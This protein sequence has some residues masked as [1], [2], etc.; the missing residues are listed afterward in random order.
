[1]WESLVVWLCPVVADENISDSYKWINN[2]S[3]KVW[4]EFMIQQDNVV[5]PES[6]RLLEGGGGQLRWRREGGG[7]R[8]REGSRVWE[9]AKTCGFPPHK[10]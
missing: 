2:L 6:Q 5:V 4:G 7:R 3:F 9:A 1:M 10:L 8:E